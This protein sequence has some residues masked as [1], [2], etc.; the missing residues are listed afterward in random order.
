MK[1]REEKTKY[2]T[3]REAGHAT[4]EIDT[5][6]RG[7]AIGARPDYSSI[8]PARSGTKPHAATRTVA[9]SHTPGRGQYA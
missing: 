2:Y 8:A 9:Q 5:P 6:E 3:K 4:K 1:R 7:E